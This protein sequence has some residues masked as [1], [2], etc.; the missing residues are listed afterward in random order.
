LDFKSGV[1]GAKWV[2]KYWDWISS[3][4]GFSSSQVNGIVKKG[5][6]ELGFQVG[7]RGWGKSSGKMSW[8]GF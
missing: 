2:V 1:E 8:I 6:G 7:E 3:R 5:A 4:G